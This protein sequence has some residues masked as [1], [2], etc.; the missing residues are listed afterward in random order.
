MILVDSSVWI[1]FFR[2]TR[3]TEV[4]VLNQHLGHDVVLIGDLILAEILQ[5][6]RTESQTDRAL[7][8]LAPFG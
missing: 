1:D 8:A 7:R 5:G 6:F 2:G 3:T 4:S